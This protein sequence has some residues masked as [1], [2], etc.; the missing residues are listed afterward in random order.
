MFAS[1]KFRDVFTFPA[2]GIPPALYATGSVAG[3]AVQIAAVGS[4]SGNIGG[5][6]KWVFIGQ[7]GSGGATTTWNAWINGGSGSAGSASVILPASSTSTFSGSNSF[8][9]TTL[10]SVVFG[11]QCN[12][13]MEIRGEYIAGLGSNFTWI[14]PVMSIT[15]ASAYAALLSL[16]FLSGSEPASNYDVTGAVFAETDAF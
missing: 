6:K 4:G 14:R 7:T 5:F 9:A 11:S 15:G 12:I 8:A 13:V 3:T 10:G 1:K 16:G 2:L